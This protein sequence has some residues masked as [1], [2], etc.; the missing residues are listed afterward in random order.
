MY[1]KTSYKF[2]WVKAIHVYVNIHVSICCEILA[3]ECQ[4]ESAK[5]VVAVRA[6]DIMQYMHLSHHSLSDAL[7]TFPRNHMIDLLWRP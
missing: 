1:G 2:K 6:V 3:K 5:F 4:S 7:G